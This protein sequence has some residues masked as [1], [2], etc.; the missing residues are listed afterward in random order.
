MSENTAVDFFSNLD[1]TKSTEDLLVSWADIALCYTWIFDKAYRHF[2]HVNYR[3][4]IPIIVFSTITGTLSMSIDSL[5]GEGGVKTGQVVIGG[6]NIFIGILS[7]LQNFFRYAQQS[8]LNLTATRDWAK[9][10]RNIKIELSIERKY[11]KPAVEFV[12]SA[13]QEYERLLNSRPVI[14]SKILEDFKRQYRHS[15]VIKPEVLDKIR[16]LI[17]DDDKN[18]ITQNNIPPVSVQNSIFNK[19]RTLI[20]RSNESPLSPSALSVST[21]MPSTKSFANLSINT[22]SSSGTATPIPIKQSIEIGSFKDYIDDKQ[23][24]ERDE[25]NFVEDNEEKNNSLSE[26]KT[27]V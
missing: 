21:P 3:F 6:V 24:D 15:D 9:L 18:M 13:R 26:L 25:I 22:N 1:W 4:T 8:E 27:Q 14:P 16:H 10:H 7:T 20:T 19:I 23:D 5:V 2:N 17:L 11:R 12:R